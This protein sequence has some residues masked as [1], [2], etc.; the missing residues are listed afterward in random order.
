[1]A[2]RDDDERKRRLKEEE[3]LAVKRLPKSASRLMRR[4]GLTEHE[5][6]VCGCIFVR[7]ISEHTFKSTCR[8]ECFVHKKVKNIPHKLPLPGRF[9]KTHSN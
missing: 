1:M 9:R 4:S 8:A 6:V 7:K 3:G 2:A 5:A